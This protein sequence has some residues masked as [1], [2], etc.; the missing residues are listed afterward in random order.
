MAAH[1]PRMIA[2]MML[3]AASTVRLIPMVHGGMET[4][5]IPI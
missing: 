2:I 1:L 5:L 4:V 3:T